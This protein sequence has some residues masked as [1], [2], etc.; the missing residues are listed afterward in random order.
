MSW[1]HSSLDPK[2]G[3]HRSQTT[4][5]ALT[6]KELRSDCSLHL[7]HNLPPDIFVD[8]YELAHYEK[9]Y[10]FEYWGTT[11]LELPVA[12]VSPHGTAVLLNITIP[13]T[14]QYDSLS[15]AVQVPMHLR[16]GRLLS[17]SPPAYHQKEIPWPVGFLACPISCTFF[18]YTP[19]DFCSLIH[20]LQR[21]DVRT[22]YP[23]CL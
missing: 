6:R 23:K 15:L 17:Q 4:T 1:L 14:V 9:A 5:L 21:L 7:L 16:Y 18:L 8:P 2:H 22:G 11:N 3:Y 19:H 12:A 13:K 20:V 10:T